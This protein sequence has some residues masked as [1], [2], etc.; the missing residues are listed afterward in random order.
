MLAAVGGEE[1][2]RGEGWEEEQPATTLPCLRVYCTSNRAFFVFCGV[3]LPPTPA[4]AF[5]AQARFCAIC[6]T[7]LDRANKA[8]FMSVSSN[9]WSVASASRSERIRSFY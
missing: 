7:I 8:Y 5:D 6:Q 4:R 1:G 2:G 3:P 9:R